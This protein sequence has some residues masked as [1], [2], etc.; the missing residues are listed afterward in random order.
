MSY[1]ETEEVDSPLI[2]TRYGRIAAQ[3][4]DLIYKNIITVIYVTI[5]LAVF[6]ILDV[7]GIL[8]IFR[9]Y[10]EATHDIIVTVISL[11]LLITLSYISLHIIR[12]KSVLDTWMKRF[13]SSSLKVSI[14]VLARSKSRE[15]I[16]HA[17]AE[18]VH[19]V[20]TYL[21]KYI[22]SNDIS[23]FIDVNIGD[24]KF[25]IL[26]DDSNVDEEF[27]HVFKEYGSIAVM[28]VDGVADSSRADEFYS[29]LLEYNRI[30]GNRI[31]LALLVADKVEG[32]ELSRHKAIDS[33]LIIEQSV[34]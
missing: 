28:V 5:A 13:E 34:D 25:D 8:H 29:K 31:G 6:S 23:R 26:I 21:Y 32:K 24:L 20:S 9:L 30:T 33:L 2:T 22:E 19:E 4:V 3:L 10:S 11:I 12:A 17:I 14:S 15:D 18:S 1:V 27:K 16:I 7:F